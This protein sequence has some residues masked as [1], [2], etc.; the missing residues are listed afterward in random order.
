MNT[1][2]KYT[3]R[4]LAFRDNDY[5]P[6]NGVSLWETCPQLAALDPAT[7]HTFFDDFYRVD[8]TGADVGWISTETEGGTGDAAITVTDA[9]GGV[10][11]IVNDD[12]DNDSVELQWNCELFKLAADKPCWFEIRLKVSEATQ[13]DFFVGLAKTNTTVIDSPA[14]AIGFKTDDGDANIDFLTDKNGTPTATDTG[15]DLVADTW[16]KLGFFF[17]GDGSTLAYVDGVLKAT[18]TTNICDD[19]EMTVTIAWQNGS[20]GAKT[21]S[22]DYVKVVQVR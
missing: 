21:M 16:V 9:A 7:A 19:E 3:R 10:L 15:S 20:A 6:A 17:D 14:D 2:A 18:H 5:S 11:S 1:K 22:V 12:L 4:N 13:S 8:I